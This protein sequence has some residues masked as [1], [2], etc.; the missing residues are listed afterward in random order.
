MIAKTHVLA[1][2]LAG[3]ILLTEASGFRVDNE[4]LFLVSVAVGSLLPDIDHPQSVIARFIPIIGIPIGR[5][6]SHRGFFHSW[7]GMTVVFTLLGMA[8]PGFKDSYTLVNGVD[9]WGIAVLW[10]GL[11]LGYFLH[12]VCDMLTVS[13]VRNTLPAPLENPHTIDADGRDCR[14]LFSVADACLYS[15]ASVWGIAVLTTGFSA[16]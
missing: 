12:I 1:G 6:V 9:V 5:L 10:H 4:A 2:L 13:G 15:V 14:V 7:F 8:L 11:L 16:P 3:G